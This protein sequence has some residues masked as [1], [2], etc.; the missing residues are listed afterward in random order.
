MLK[1]PELVDLAQKPF[2]S[3]V[4]TYFCQFGTRWQKRARFLMGHLRP[5]ELARLSGAC[6][7]RAGIRTRTGRPRL[8]LEGC[9]GPPLPRRARKPWIGPGPRALCLG[10]GVSFSKFELSEHP[11]SGRH[12]T[13][14]SVVTQQLL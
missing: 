13:F 11:F 2:V 10:P 14:E 4:V 3:T 5:D 7:G 12:G 8:Q 9:D 1:T 6:D